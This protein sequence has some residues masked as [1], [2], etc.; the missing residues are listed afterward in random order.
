[1][2]CVR[3][4]HERAVIRHPLVLYLISRTSTA[5]ILASRTDP[6]CRDSA[7]RRGAYVTDNGNVAPRDP[8]QRA[9]RDARE[10]YLR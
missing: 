2:F 10:C 5:Y 8:R 3:A 7:V 4:S 9:I 6:E 1:M